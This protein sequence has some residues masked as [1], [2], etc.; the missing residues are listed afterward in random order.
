MGP[1]QGAGEG[2]VVA[3]GGMKAV[4]AEVVVVLA[5]DGEV[6]AMRGDGISVSRTLVEQSTDYLQGWKSSS[7]RLPVFVFPSTYLGEGKTIS[8]FSRGWTI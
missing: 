4:V 1:E 7:T 3:V 5:A 8:G 6:P 2:V